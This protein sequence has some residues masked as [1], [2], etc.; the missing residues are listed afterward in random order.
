VTF[1]STDIIFA[2]DEAVEFGLTKSDVHNIQE[3][4][5]YMA[6]DGKH[7]LSLFKK[8]KHTLAFLNTYV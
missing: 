5:I 1:G 4:D 6:A 7:R 3:A 2:V 8:S